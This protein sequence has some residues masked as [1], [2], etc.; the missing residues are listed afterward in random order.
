MA[1]IVVLAATLVAT[2]TASAHGIWFAERSSQLAIV[3]GIGA[4]DLDM[5]K[6]LP[7]ITNVSAFNALQQ[8]VET[9]YKATEHLVLVNT[10]NH[11]AIVSAVLDNG[12]WSKA[13]DGEWTKATR[14][15]M[16][17]AV[18]S[19]SNVKY[20]VHLLSPLVDPLGALPGQTLQIVP[21]AEVL[22]DKMNAELGLRILY[23]GEPVAGA[24]IIVDFLND[25]DAKPIVSDEHGRVSIKIRN[26]GLNVIGALYE[27]PHED[28]A[29]ADQYESMA[30]LSFVLPHEPE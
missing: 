16:P 6:R 20:A 18:I 4:D 26:Q 15:E 22:P 19:T 17:D 8:P 21:E 3:Y 7:L 24:R 1:G 28:P 11:P 27:S 10:E 30:T 23:K 5:V 29:I 9:S 12:T 25:P 2:T 14:S 13:A